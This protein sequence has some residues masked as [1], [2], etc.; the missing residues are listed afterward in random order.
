[1]K[2]TIL[3]GIV[4]LCPLASFAAD[5]VKPFDA[6]PGLWET[7]TSMDMPGVPAMPQIPEEALSKM[8]PQQRAQ[9]E[10]MMKGRGGAGPRT[11]TTKSCLTKESLSKAFAFRENERACTQ[12]VVSSSSS[13]Q[14]IHL[15]CNQGQVKSSGDITVERIDAEHAKGTM[16]M[17]ASEGSTPIGPMNMKVSFNSKWVSADCGDVKPF[18]EQ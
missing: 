6:K 18:G 15:E 14:E 9:M 10:A 7:T 17:K 2:L 3:I 13:K 11:T 1:V 4:A 5:E 16:L 12:K 8:T